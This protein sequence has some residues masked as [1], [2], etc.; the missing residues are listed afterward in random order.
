MCSEMEMSASPKS[1]DYVKNVQPTSSENTAGSENGL[2]TFTR[3]FDVQ[4]K[5]RECLKNRIT[6]YEFV[7]KIPMYSNEKLMR[8]VMNDISEQGRMLSVS[9]EVEVGCMNNKIYIKFNYKN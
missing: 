5:I 6:Y 1:N 3:L 8:M 7:L 4:S 9:F 2:P